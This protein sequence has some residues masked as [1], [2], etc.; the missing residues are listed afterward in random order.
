MVYK[1]VFKKMPETGIS[2]SILLW[3]LYDPIENYRDP[4]W[5]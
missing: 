5:G 1:L 2:G 4:D 3:C